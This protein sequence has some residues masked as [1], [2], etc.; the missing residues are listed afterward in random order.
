MRDYKMCIKCAC[1]QVH[2][3][4]MGQQPAVLIVGQFV[5]N[6]EKSC[7]LCGTTAC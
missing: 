4:W 1:D 6:Y 5:R 7:V 2:I 3:E